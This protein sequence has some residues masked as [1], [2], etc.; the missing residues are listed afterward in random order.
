MF[1]FRKLGLM[2]AAAALFA[3]PSVAAPV[4]GEMAPEIDAVDAKGNPFKLS[5]HKGSIVVLEW[6]NHECPFVVKHYE[7]GN[8]QALQKAAAADG[9]KWV[10]IISSAP[11]HQGHVSDADALKI[12][13]EKGA[14][15]AVILRDES[16]QIG[17]LYD[18]QTTPHMYV[19][20]A[21]GKLAYMGAI[22]DNSSPRAS[23]VEGAT[24]YV[25][26]A[27]ADLKAGN[28]VATPQTA[29]YGCSVKYA[30]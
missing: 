20:D 8:M 4:V 24:N 1:D 3:M 27:L 28:P 10:S 30:K 2:V 23:T 14:S 5:D 22:D 12:A 17:G 29:P 21:E 7:G 18:A 6:T 13:S 19:V 26:A 11:G 25:T 16:G 9:V 15:P